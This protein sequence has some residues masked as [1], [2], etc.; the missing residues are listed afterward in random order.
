MRTET[1]LGEWLRHLGDLL[2]LGSA[3]R[4]AEM[5]LEYRPRY[6]PVLRALDAGARTVSDIRDRSRLTQ[7][8]VSQTLALM[9]ADG[10]VTRHALPDRRSSRVLLTANGEDLVAILTGHWQTIFTAVDALEAEIGHPLRRVLADT[11]AA[12]ER[13]GFAERLRDAA[14]PAP[15]DA[16]S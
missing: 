14:H 13:R 8:A 5:G 2:D 1:G 7:G 11:V 10:L 15:Q 16:G 12:L 3:Q 6:T 4:Y 9:E